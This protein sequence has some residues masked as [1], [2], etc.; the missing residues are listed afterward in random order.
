MLDP[1]RGRT[2]T[3]QLFA[4]ARDDRPWAAAIRR[5]WPTST[6]PTAR[7]S[8]RSHISNG[9]TGIPGRRLRRLGSRL[10]GRN[11]V[12]LAFC[13]F[14]RRKFYELS[15]ARPCADRRR[16]GW[17][18]RRALIALRSRSVAARPSS[19][20]RSARSAAGRW[21]RRF[22]A[23]AARQAATISQ[24]TKLAEAI[25]LR[26]V[27]LARPSGLFLDDGRVEIDNNVVERAIRPPALTRKNA[28]FAGSD[29]GAGALGYRHA[30]L[31]RRDLQ[32]Q[33]RRAV[34]DTSPTSSP[35]SSK[36]TSCRAA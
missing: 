18:A 22:G 29:A 15:D 13:F 1:G 28:L 3:G 34:P 8:G 21:S 36:A 20:A 5:A 23:V 25:R 7:P 35:A 4:Y 19:A 6:L 16:G 17:R 30:P 24:K 2:K 31:A 12:Q 27:A 14:T 10:A 33:R 26:A 32:V 9:F 11:D